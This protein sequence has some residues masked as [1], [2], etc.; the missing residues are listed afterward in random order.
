LAVAKDEKMRRT[1]R[2]LVLLLLLVMAACSADDQSEPEMT[3][4]ATAPVTSTPI[5][6]VQPSPIPTAAG[7]EVTEQTLVVWWP[8]T[9]APGERTDI[10]GVLDAQIAEFDESED[11]LIQLEFRLKR[12]GDVGGVMST[13]RSATLVAPDVVPDV[14]LIRREDLVSAVESGLIYP[15][16]GLV[17]A[18]IIG[19]LYGSSLEL[20]EVNGQLYGLPYMLDVRHSVAGATSD[21]EVIE[22]WSF[23][24]LLEREQQWVFPARRVSGLNSMFYLQYLDAGGTPPAGDGSLRLNRSALLTVLSFYEQANDLGLIPVEVLEYTSPQD[25]VTEL[26][27]GAIDTAIVSS[28]IYLDEVYAERSLLPGPIPTAS[29]AAVGQ[30]NGWM[31]VVTTS[32]ADRQEIAARFLNWMMNADRQVEYAEVIHMLPSRQNAVQQLNTSIIDVAMF[33]TILTNAIIPL[34]E[35]LNTT[36]ARTLQNA[37]ISV[38]SGDSTAADAVDL[39]VDQLDAG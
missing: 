5:S 23:D 30:I 9:L 18:N 19:D 13:L 10:T 11:G 12:Y 31:W 35:T 39:V 15:L 7:T 32:N 34:P 29:G 22:D 16:D 37:F 27:I 17:A 20:G 38:I 33:D 36:T 4:E 2:I 28:T 6:A 1:V 26:T 21:D 3:E 25:Y 24:A 8:D 14:T